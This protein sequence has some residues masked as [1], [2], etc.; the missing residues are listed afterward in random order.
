MET[1]MLP[2]PKCGSQ[3]IATRDWWNSLYETKYFAECYDCGCMVG[4]MADPSGWVGAAYDTDI[5]AIEAWNRR[6]NDDE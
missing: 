4:F 3:N 6:A 1:K 5:Q 2:C